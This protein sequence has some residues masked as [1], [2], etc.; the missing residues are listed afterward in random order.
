MNQ[1]TFKPCPTKPDPLGNPAVIHLELTPDQTAQLEAAGDCLIAIA[2]GSYPHRAGRLVISAL[3]VSMAPVRDLLR[4]YP[5]RGI[6]VAR[7]LPTNPPATS[8]F[9]S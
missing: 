2:R 6:W 3:P 4:I 7:R 8:K 1:V 9:Y 5:S